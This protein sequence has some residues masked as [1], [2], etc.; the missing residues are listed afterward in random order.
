MFKTRRLLFIVVTAIAIAL[1]AIGLPLTQMSLSPVSAASYFST[2]TGSVD[3]DQILGCVANGYVTIPGGTH[4][5]A[6]PALLQ[7]TGVTIPTE[8]DKWLSCGPVPN[9]DSLILN[10]GVKVYVPNVGVT[11]SVGR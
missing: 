9:T 1:L 5:Y 8:G 3:Y 6:D 11:Y 2:D 7:D 10:V 4:L